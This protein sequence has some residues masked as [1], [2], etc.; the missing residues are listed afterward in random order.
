MR[1]FFLCIIIAAAAFGKPSVRMLTYTVQ[2][3]NVRTNIFYRIVDERGLVSTGSNDNVIYDTSFDPEYTLRHWGF[4]NLTNGNYLRVTNDG[5]VIH[6][7]SKLRGS[8]PVSKVITIPKNSRHYPGFDQAAHK[9][10]LLGTNILS[11]HM[12]R[13]D[14]GDVFEM[15]VKI[16]GRETIA[17]AGKPV[18]TIKVHGGLTGILA[19]M[20]SGAEYWFRA[21]DYEYVRFKGQ[22]GP[23][24]SPEAIMELVDEKVIK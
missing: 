10:F 18:D 21:G 19:L 13:P 23:P 1:P 3:T 6:F 17:I 7:A 2:G 11:F 15:E 20:W 5:G 12:M 4:I 8:Q 16:T 22:M 9:M 24:G 14:T